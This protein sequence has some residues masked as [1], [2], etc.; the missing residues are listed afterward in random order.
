MKAIRVHEYGPPSVMKLEETADPVAGPRQV[1]VNVRAAGVNPVDTLIRLGTYHLKPPLPFI[2]GVD[3]AGVV[4]A[5]GP[6]VETFAPGDRV[7][8]GGT[9]SGISFGTYAASVV[10]GV[11][12]V[13]CLPERVTFEQGAAVHVPYVTAYRA[14]FQRALSQPGETLLVHGASGGVGVAAVQLA[15]AHGMRVI[16]TAGTA[17]GETLVMNQGAHH[18]VD[19]TKPDYV[20]RIQSL[21]GGRGVDVI[22]E[23][24]GHLNLARDLDMIAIGGRI[25]IVGNRA[26]I[27]VNMRAA[28][29]RDATV[30]G[31]TVWNIPARPRLSSMRRSRPGWRTARSRRWWAVNFRSPTPPGRTRLCSSGERMGKSC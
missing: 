6:D 11:Q 8:V 26:P 23:M 31:F 30:T 21:T 20:S 29:N 19:H 1:V 15:R 2:P 18:V 9:A 3:A 17:R 22:V 5:V 16:G 7:Y 12:Q 27:E 4:A 14:L 25:V 24:A 13:H 10:C 28:M